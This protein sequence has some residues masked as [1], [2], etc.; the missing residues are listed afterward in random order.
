MA[1]SFKAQNKNP[2][3]VVSLFLLFRILMIRL[4]SKK[5]EEVIKRL[6]PH[7]L[8]ELVSVFDESQKQMERLI[9]GGVVDESQYST[10]KEAIKVVELMSQLNI[11]EF[12]MNQWMFLFDGFG[13][14]HQSANEVARQISGQSQNNR[15]RFIFDGQE[16]TGCSEIFQPYLIK[17]MCKQQVAFTPR[18]H[19]DQAGDKFVLYNQ[20]K[21]FEKIRVQEESNFEE[22][23]PKE[24]D[25]PLLIVDNDLKDKSNRG[26]N[27]V[28]D[29][30][31]KL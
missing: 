28:R 20:V 29:Y 16:E 26:L 10:T 11:E 25:R 30:S 13:I 8:A 23:E 1:D 24:F 27:F 18:R 6:W 19:N 7:L 5:L 12:Q 4:G 2:S 31:E 17:F 3:F 9:A 14:Q 15:D 21:D 22:I